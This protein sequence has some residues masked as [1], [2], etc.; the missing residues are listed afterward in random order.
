MSQTPPP[1]SSSARSYSRAFVLALVVTLV[2]VVLLEH[3]EDDALRHVGLAF[4]SGASWGETYPFSVFETY[5]DYDPWY[6]FDLVLHGLAWLVSWLP[7]SRLLH[8]FLLTEVLALALTGG[9]LALA[10]S[11][12]RIR[13]AIEDGPSFAIA[14]GVLV[15]VMH[16]PILRLAL[17]RPFAFG[18]LFLLYAVGGRGVVRGVLSG[19]VVSFFYPYLAWIYTIP[20]VVA[21]L[22]RG[23]RTFALG[24]GISLGV[25]LLVQPASFWKLVSA[26]ILTEG[27][28]DQASAYISE[29]APASEHLGFVAVFALAWLVLLPALPAAS[30]RLRESHLLALL[31]LVP[32]FKYIR[33][34]IDVELVLL[35]AIYGRDA[36]GA[37]RGPVDRVVGWWGQRLRAIT[38]RLRRRESEEGR[39]SRS[40]LPIIA[41]LY[42]VVTLLMGLTSL[43]QHVSFVEY[44]ERLEPIPEGS[45]VLTDFNSQY[46]ILYTRPDLRVVPSCNIAFPRPDIEEAYHRY[47]QEGD[48]C[49]LAEQIG[50][51]FLLDTRGM[52]LDP[53]RT[54]CLDLLV[55]EE[56]MR[57]WEITSNPDILH[58][59]DP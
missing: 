29:I 34:F 41:V 47:F 48:A 15:L 2:C 32:S 7:G 24:V 33:Y 9:L 14:M 40:L 49:G 52:Y 55:D 56:T 58:E 20:V 59:V 31:F 25:S 44:Q 3:P 8:Q 36:V 10:V 45:L 30:R 38:G 27:A 37:L 23:S 28:R 46:R 5:A 42:V 22:V 21:H 13:E 12:S 50:A 17:V 39:S 18:T 1:P 19:A 4:G 43:V 57:L 11:R 35:F 6:G 54:G 16:Q 26:Q 51:D 53:T